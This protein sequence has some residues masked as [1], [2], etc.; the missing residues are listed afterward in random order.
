MPDAEPK[1]DL[2]LLAGG[3]IEAHLDRGAGIQGGSHLA[4]KVYARHRGRSAQRT[5]APQEFSPI[6]GYGAGRI[7]H[8]EERNPVAELRVV[9]VARKQCAAIRV[10]FGDHV[11][12]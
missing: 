6:A 5:V 7:V 8:V 1:D 9:R 2:T 10:N 3:Q 12:A 11:H 4:G